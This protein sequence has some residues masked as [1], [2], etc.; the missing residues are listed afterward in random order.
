MS[1][2]RL[3]TLVGSTTYIYTS[4]VLSVGRLHV[5]VSSDVITSQLNLVYEFEIARSDV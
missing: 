2:N 5:Q 4:I 1:M 3:F